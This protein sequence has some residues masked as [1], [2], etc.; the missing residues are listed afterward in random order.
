MLSKFLSVIN[1]LTIVY[2][3]VYVCVCSNYYIVLEK[4][5]AWTKSCQEEKYLNLQFLIFSYI[6]G[7]T[8]LSFFS[9]YLSWW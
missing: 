5:F 8:Y 1:Q 7:N 2:V 4:K 3:C 9:L 6:F